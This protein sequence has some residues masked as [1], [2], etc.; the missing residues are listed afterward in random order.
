VAY[1]VP[2]GGDA[3]GFS[4]TDLRESLGRSLPYYM[5]P[6]GWV[7]L[8]ALP[9]NA[10][11]KVD[12]RALPAPDGVRPDLG[13]VYVAPRT[14]L[15]EV[16]AGIWCEVL[17]IERVGVQDN[18]FTLGGHSLLA[19]QV[20]S[21]V[22]EAFGVELPLRSLF[23]KP[24]VAALALE[25]E[26]LRSGERRFQAPPLKPVAREG[27]LPPSFAQERL[28]FLDQ[29]QPGLTAYNVPAPV[30]LVGRLAVGALVEAL[31]EIVRRHEALRTVFHLPAGEAEPVQ[32]I[33]PAAA[34]PLPLVDLSAVPPAPREAEARRLAATQ[35]RLPF[36]LA[37]GPLL[38]AALLRLAGP[39][40]PQGPEH[41][42]LLCLHHIAT[43]GWSMGVL[44]REVA[45][46]Y[47]AFSSGLPSP[48]AE[49]PVQYADYA[50][51]QRGWLAGEVLEAQI[52]YWKQA[53]RGVPP[54]LDLP[55]DRPRPPVQTFR[56]AHRP[57]FFPP[58]VAEPLRQLG[59]TQ[60]LTSFMVLLAALHCLLHRVSGQGVVAVGSPTANRGRAELEGIIGF[61][62]N[63]LVLAGD[64]TDE[65]AFRDLLAQV[66]ETS[67]GAYA[68]QDLPFEKLVE[69]LAPE[70][71]L[72]HTPLFQVLFV[73]QG[74]AAPAAT[75][76]AAGGLALS[77]LAAEMGAAKFDLT[78]EVEERGK[79]FAASLEFNT[80]LFDGATID[81]LL[82]HFRALLEAVLAAP[83][84]RVAELSLLSAVE[85]RQIVV[86]WNATGRELP[87]GF[88]HEWIAAQAKRSPQA[89][90]VACGSESLTYEE[91][92]RRAN[93]L[94][95]RLRRL[96]IGP[97][98][99]VGI[100]LERSIEMVV[101][102]L[103]VLK[104]GG[105]YVPLDPSYPAERLAFMRE[106]ARLNVLLSGGDPPE[107][108]AEAPESGVGPQNA[109]YVIYTSG[110]TGR[111]KGV[112]IPHGALANFLT[113][114]AGKP[115]L[116]A[117]DRLLAVTSLSFDIAGLELYL[118]L[119]VGGRIVLAN[120]E[121]TADGRR[122]QALI[123]ES[124]IT[125]LQATPATWRLLLESGWQGG[126]GLKA[127]CGGEALSPVLAAALRQR[128]SSLWNVY[129]P[130][131]TTVWS[132]VEEIRS[133]GPILIG[134][135]IANTE[136]YVVDGEN[137]PVPVGVPGELL[138]GGAG[139]A[140]GYLD[141]PEL[142]AEK[143]VPNPFGDSGSRLYRTGDLARWRVAGVLE[144]L[145]RID[146]QVKVRGFRIELGEIEATLRRHPQVGEAVLVARG[147][148]GEQNLVAY[149]AA[150]EGAG[151]APEVD[152][153]RSFLSAKLPAYMVPW[154]FVVLPAL[155]LTANG[156][157]D[158]R[159]LPDPEREAWGAAPEIEEPRSAMERTIAGI[160]RQLL[161]LDRVGIDDNFFDSGGHSLLAV[162]LYHQLKSA[163]G[164]EF[165]LVA[166]FEHTTIRAL[167]RY[168]EAGE[169]APASRLRGQDRGA[170]RRE[171]AAGRR[172]GRP[173]AIDSGDAGAMDHDPQE[174]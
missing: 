125:V 42:L 103:G 75:P 113:S 91:L 24:T 3:S 131:E 30:R 39:E 35:T 115:G 102:V 49:L 27:G 127:L 36:D 140:R 172:R 156:K 6:S 56:G 34:V 101:G 45:A 95:W 93:G 46:L 145:G 67:L 62:A 44:M 69:E 169:A 85:R 135:P 40:G 32:A 7:L 139:L 37:R 168:L 13:A 119:T 14:A 163:T 171:A 121:D 79:G 18:F 152:E 78:L 17:R 25:I 10:N 159:A 11:G 107:E 105:A 70:R 82:G 23:E 157:I 31:R 128:V 22:R 15:E 66:R 154:A 143:F 73:F 124:G 1:L 68:H 80:D 166:L 106:D 89:V 132:T 104:A 141:R 100:A 72:A 16:V 2:Q 138:L 90:A 77:P 64:L 153:L 134:R 97:E 81:R 118:P 144:C 26:S 111:P 28:W 29:L 148:P 51:W 55:T 52:A 83:E 76:P 162:R 98:M 123:A 19:T 147:E 58:E 92:D 71:S 54:L 146:H 160:W 126:E 165:P 41:V 155:P 57:A 122:L 110:S 130:T 63:T 150:Q 94:A 21:R 136:A 86:E 96:G 12:R 8:D 173:G 5:I 74:A 137:Q 112:Q 20:G 61:F 50:A 116:G 99:R 129:G 170:R 164:R 158:R 84:G 65:P 114:M 161:R 87:E 9:L 43:D 142:T 151:G 88:V 4:V 47:D 133:D 149:V 174:L 48:L 117:D 108:S 59:R 38:R 60:G 109:A 167:A 120:R 53:L 33:L